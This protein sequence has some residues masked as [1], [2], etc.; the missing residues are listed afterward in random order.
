MDI[1]HT[2]RTITGPQPSDPYAMYAAADSGTLPKPLVPAPTVAPTKPSLP[3]KPA[4]DRNSKPVLE[5]KPSVEKPS[6]EP[7]QDWERNS[8]K[9]KILG[10]QNIPK[11]SAEPNEGMSVEKRY[12]A[13][14]NNN[15]KTVA[16]KKLSYVSTESKKENLRA[17]QAMFDEK[18]SEST[19]RL[20]PSKQ[21]SVNTNSN[22]VINNKPVE[23]PKP[24]LKKQAP[25]PPGGSKQFHKTVISVGGG[26][27][28]QKPSVN[29]T[30]S[31]P[32]PQVNTAPAP[33]GSKAQTLP[34]KANPAFHEQPQSSVPPSSQTATESVYSVAMDTDA[35]YS[36]KADYNPR[37]P[38][39]NTQQQQGKGTEGYSYAAVQNG[40]STEY[41]YTAVQ[42][43][44]SR[45]T[46]TSS[47]GQNELVFDSFY[48]QVQRAPNGTSS[49]HEEQD[50]HYDIVDIV[51]Q[52]SK[53]KNVNSNQVRK[54]TK[55]LQ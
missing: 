44:G 35:G 8:V 1:E 5:R 40:T 36:V 54:F 27:G 15:E 22:P 29:R 26:S 10:I 3:E 47:T 46:S 13:T 24:D 38:M 50:N 51:N 4:V 12:L 19:Q 37:A 39:V 9:K 30:V 34:A 2:L 6:T 11:G 14:V 55:I 16:E 21:V 41:S 25:V 17:K 43:G 42:G 7:K 32:H 53:N 18:H 52:T 31:T 20:M 49:R 45:P 33:S 48:S 28:P 23:P